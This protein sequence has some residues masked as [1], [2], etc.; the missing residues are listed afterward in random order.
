MSST[1]TTT[2]THHDTP[3]RGVPRRLLWVLLAA[4]VVANGICSLAGLPFVGSAFGVLALV[5]GGLLVRDHYRRRART[6]VGHAPSGRP[7]A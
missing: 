3:A 5:A 4:A 1:P 6:E 7:A 2:G